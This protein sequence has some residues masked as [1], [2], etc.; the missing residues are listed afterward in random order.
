MAEPARAAAIQIPLLHA[1]RAQPGRFAVVGV[2]GALIAF[3]VLW[4]VVIAAPF[5]ESGIPNWRTTTYGSAAGN[6]GGLLP[7]PP[8][9]VPPGPLLF[10]VASGFS[11]IFGLM[12]V[13]NMAHGSFY[14]LGGYIA[15]EVQQAMTGQGFALPGPDVQTWGWG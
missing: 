13:V 9:S 7:L 15:Y 5:P 4:V 3:L 12:R 10:I 1:V 8:A 14:L 11:L 6:P 2:V